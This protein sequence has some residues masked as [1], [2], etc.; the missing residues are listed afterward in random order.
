MPHKKDK[1]RIFHTLW[2]Q[3]GKADEY[4]GFPEYPYSVEGAPALVPG[5]KFRAD[6]AFPAQ[7]V[8]IEIDGGVYGFRFYNRK[9]ERVEWRRGGHSSISGQL[10]DMERG[11]L[12]SAYGWRVLRFTPKQ[13]EENPSKCIK[14]VVRALRYGKQGIT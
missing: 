8:I 3:I 9:T 4:Q 5:R 7:K 1:A 11:N 13:L 10:Q 2:L 6:F 12:L 14:L